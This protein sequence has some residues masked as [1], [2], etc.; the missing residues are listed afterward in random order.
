MIK[1]G[2][3]SICED[4]TLNNEAIVIDFK[5]TSPILV[6]KLNNDDESTFL[7]NT[8]G[9]YK[10][11]TNDL[12][13]KFKNYY[14]TDSLDNFSFIIGC[15]S[16]EPKKDMY[17]NSTYIGVEGL[18]RLETNEETMEVINNLGLGIGKD[19]GFGKMASIKRKYIY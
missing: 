17:K 2:L 8:V 10:K 9:F 3:H 15:Y 12:K 7:P 19:K 14:K 18:F 1:K 16:F 6:A 5:T 13:A 11:I 4:K